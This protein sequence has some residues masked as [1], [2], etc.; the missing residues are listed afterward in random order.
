[1]IVTDDRIG[2][3]DIVKIQRVN[4][5]LIPFFSSYVQAGFASPAENYIERICSLDDLCITNPEAT[6]FVRVASDSMT[7]DRIE[8]GDVLIVDCSREAVDGK[9]AV[10]W[11]NG[12]HTVKRLHY[13]GEMIVLMPSNPKYDPIY[14]HES[15]S[16]RV[17]GVVT[18]V[19]QKPI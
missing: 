7:G 4:G 1:M 12:G 19:I 6:Y 14:V 13:A 8:P 10:V 17:F 18:F 5:Y 16:F 11:I 3:V 2:D 15:D 9:I